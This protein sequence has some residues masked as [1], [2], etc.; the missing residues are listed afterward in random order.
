V[1]GLAPSS[2]NIHLPV[3]AAHNREMRAACA[4][5]GWAFWLAIIGHSGKTALTARTESAW[6]R[7]MKPVPIKPIRNWPR[8]LG[9]PS[10]EKMLYLLVPFA[11]TSFDQNLGTSFN[12]DV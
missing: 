4:I 9:P 5:C 6:G 1:V 3:D 2:F 11:S 8:I 12:P 7:P 10:L